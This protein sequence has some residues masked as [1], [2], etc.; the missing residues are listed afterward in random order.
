MACDVQINID[1]NGNLLV[2]CHVNRGTFGRFRKT[3]IFAAC[4]ME[5]SIGGNVNCT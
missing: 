1:T 4:N 5:V 2:T 3:S